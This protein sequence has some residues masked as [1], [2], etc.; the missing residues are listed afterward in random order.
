MRTLVVGDI[1]GSYKALVQVLERA[2]FN[3]SEDELITLGDI[4]D[5]WPDV[6]ECVQYLMD[7]PFRIDIRGNHDKWCQDWMEFGLAHEDWVRQGGDGTKLNYENANMDAAFDIDAHRD[8]FRRQI[9]FYVDDNNRAFVHGGYMSMD[10][11]G[12]D[13]FKIYYWDRSLWDIALS[14]KNSQTI[15]KKLK[16]YEN[17][18]IGHTNTMAWNTHEPMHAHNVWNIDTSAGWEGK[19]TVMDVETKEY[20]QSDFVKDLYPENYIDR[21]QGI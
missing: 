17:I 20:W 21:K 9:N 2:G 4:V 15:P 12:N 11:L 7:I 5:G 13:S 10:G 16:H 3:P 8:F 1:H 18:F 14:G 6:V 19:L